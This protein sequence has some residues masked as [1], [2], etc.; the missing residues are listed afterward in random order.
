MAALPAR[1][2]A[3]ALLEGD[4]LGGAVV[5]DDLGDHLGARNQ[6]LPS[7]GLSPP[8]M[9]TSVNSTLAPA[10]PSSFSMVKTS[11]AA[12]R[13][14]LPPVF[15]T[16][17]IIDFLSLY[18]PA[19]TTVRC[20]TPGWGALLWR[21]PAKST[22]EPPAGLRETA[23]ISAVCRAPEVRRRGGM[24]LVSAHHFRKAAARLARTGRFAYLHPSRTLACS[25]APG[26]AFR[27]GPA[28]PGRGMHPQR[29]Q[30]A[31]HGAWRGGRA[32]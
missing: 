17:Y 12:T 15:M 6:G 23:R 18:C 30:I 32:G 14:C 8:T 31:S 2:L 3:P 22:P 20:R 27:S 29:L 24:R 21:G 28:T 13:Y 11:L 10:S 7:L 1:I 9:S 16:A 5:L 4:D 19:G 26:A 25:A